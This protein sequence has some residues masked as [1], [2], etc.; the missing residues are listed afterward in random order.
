VNIEGVGDFEWSDLSSLI[1]AGSSGAANIIKATQTPTVVPYSQGVI[2][3]PQTG[4]LATPTGVTAA[5]AAGSITPIVIMGGLA[6][7][8]V[9]LMSRGR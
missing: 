2:F 8:A 7:F 1:A 5:N 4:Q 9:L 3:N 6:V